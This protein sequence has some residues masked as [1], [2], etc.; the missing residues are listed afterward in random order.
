MS[1]FA[2]LTFTLLEERLCELD[3]QAEFQ[4]GNARL[5]I[6]SMSKILKIGF[7]GG[8]KMA[9]AMAKGIVSAGSVIVLESEKS[10]S[11]RLWKFPLRFRNLFLLTLKS[12]D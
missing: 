11:N 4:F 5:K 12:I 6:Q 2:S 7:I 1:D 3:N 9:Q 10:F 8:G